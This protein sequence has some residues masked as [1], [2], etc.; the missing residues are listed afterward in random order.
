VPVAV[1]DDEG[2]LGGQ[3]PPGP[4]AKSAEAGGGLVLGPCEQ[5]VGK[6]VNLLAL[7]PLFLPRRP[8]APVAPSNRFQQVLLE[9]V[10]ERM[11]DP[12]VRG[13]EQEM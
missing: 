9:S 3:H 6:M 11:G 2:V 5:A 1:P 4:R 13:E 12:V 10:Q 8:E 7:Q